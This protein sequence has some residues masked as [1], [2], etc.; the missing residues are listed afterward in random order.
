MKTIVLSNW[1]FG[2]CN[3]EGR[4]SNEEVS[5]NESEIYLF[6]FAIAN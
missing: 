6:Y 5:K 1:D 4:N 2:R 3:L